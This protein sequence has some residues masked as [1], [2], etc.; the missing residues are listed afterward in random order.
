VVH[1]ALC[2]HVAEGGEPGTASIPENLQDFARG[3]A[4]LVTPGVVT[5]FSEAIAAGTSA[6]LTRDLHDTD[7]WPALAT[8]VL[9]DDYGDNL[10]WYYLGRAAEGMA[11]CDAA[12]RYYRRSRELSA[13]FWT[14]CFSIACYGFKIPEILDE[15]LAAVEAM[16]AAGRCVEAP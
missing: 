8:V 16:R 9:E 10:R 6:V 12:E 3:R 13:S 7:Q 15:R 14:R 11:L 4:E 2:D 5:G 1:E